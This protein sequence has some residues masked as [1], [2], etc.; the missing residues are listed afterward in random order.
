MLFQDLRFC[1]STGFMFNPDDISLLCI[2]ELSPVISKAAGK[3]ETGNPP[4]I[5]QPKLEC[6]CGGN[7]NTGTTNGE[8]SPRS[9]SI[10]EFKGVSM[11]MS[12]KL[13]LRRRCVAPEGVLLSMTRHL[14]R[15]TSLHEVPRY[16]H[17]IS[18]PYHL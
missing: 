3:V 13:D 18:S 11:L 16:P 7:G 15:R 14:S 12:K 1:A 5:L 17:P 2:G 6:D 10:N 8:V 9:S 4:R